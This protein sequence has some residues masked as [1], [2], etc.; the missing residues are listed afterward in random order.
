VGVVLPVLLAIFAVGPV[1][2]SDGALTGAWVL[3]GDRTA[4]EASVAAAVDRALA[5]QGAMV[6]GVARPRILAMA[7]VCGRYDTRR[8]DNGFS[9]TCD[10]TSSAVSALDRVERAGTRPDGSPYRLS[11][12]SEDDAVVLRFAAE[13]GGQVVRYRVDGDVLILDKTLH[14]ERLGIDVVWT[15][16]YLRIGG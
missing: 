15:L 16:R 9:V 13:Q 3:D 8:Q 5:G 14:V 12:W 10:G 11:G 6:R 4:A 2:A 7:T 1:A